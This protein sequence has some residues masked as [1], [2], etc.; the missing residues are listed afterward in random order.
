MAVSVVSDAIKGEIRVADKPV[1]NTLAL[2][3]CSQSPVNSQRLTVGNFEVQHRPCV[4]GRQLLTVIMIIMT[5][6]MITRGRFI[7]QKIIS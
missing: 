3:A 7:Q 1:T 2:E 4:A 5:M 6:M